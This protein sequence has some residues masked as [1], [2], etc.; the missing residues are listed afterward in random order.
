MT[1]P[2]S[3][4]CV[5]ASSKRMLAKAPGLGAD[6]FVIDLE[7]AVLPAQKD[8]AREAGAAALED[9][10]W[11]GLSA[12]VRINAP[13]SPWCHLDICAVAA[14]ARRPHAIVVPKVEG[15]GD[16]DFVDRLLDGVDLHTPIRIH[17]LIETAPGLANIAAIAAASPRLE[18]LIVGYADLAL[19]LGGKRDLDG[20]RWA[21]DT[22]LVAARAHGLYAIDGPF[23]GIEPDADFEAAVSRAAREVGFDGKWAIHP[24]QLAALNRA[25]APT[26][27]EVESARAVLAALDQAEAGAARLDGQMV[28]EPIRQA[29]MR[30]LARAGD[31]S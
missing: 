8:A 31:V 20:W 17:A 19:S 6:Q 22:V 21:Q 23:L 12:V 28:D 11:D 14:L 9:E 7:D 30:T 24:G 26:A 4:L 25:F 10:A 29:A 2:R 27:D 13:R 1:S 3:C 16:V 5:P 15:A 18:A